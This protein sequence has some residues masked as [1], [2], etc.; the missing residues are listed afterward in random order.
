M[1]RLLQASTRASCRARPAKCEGS[2]AQ[3]TVLPAGSEAA[4]VPFNGIPAQSISSSGRQDA[5]AC[6]TG[7]HSQ[8]S[9]ALEDSAIQVSLGDICSAPCQAPPI[10]WCTG[11]EAYTS[12]IPFA[13]QHLFSPLGV[14]SGRQAYA[15]AAQAL[16]APPQQLLAVRQASNERPVLPVQRHARSP[17]RRAAIIARLASRY[18]QS[19]ALVAPRSSQ[20]PW[21]LLRV[22]CHLGLN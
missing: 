17:R 19:M 9:A 11:R 12:S 4:S 22:S 21:T 18:A 20:Q 1:Q 15:S 7:R 5:P 6:Q 2:A 16:L 13:R 10:H 8:G 14:P 3:I